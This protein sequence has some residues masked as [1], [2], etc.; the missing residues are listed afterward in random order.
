M[1]TEL[2][3]Y[4]NDGLF[5]LLNSITM[6]FIMCFNPLKPGLQSRALCGTVCALPIANSTCTNWRIAS[7]MIWFCSAYEMYVFCILLHDYT[8]YF[9]GFPCYNVSY[10]KYSS[11]WPYYIVIHLISV[12]LPTHYLILDIYCQSF[13][14]KVTKDLS[15]PTHFPHSI[16][17]IEKHIARGRAKYML[18]KQKEVE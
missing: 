16:S 14:D 7:L 17:D 15:K 2:Y 11:V 18:H 4:W 6:G 5:V 12:T 10:Y 9:I 3:I 1:K 13:S 8:L